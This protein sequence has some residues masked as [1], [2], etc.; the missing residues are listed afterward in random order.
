MKSKII[1]MFVFIILFCVFCICNISYA[2]ETGVVYIESDKE[3]IEKDDEVEVSINLKDAKT[4]AC[5]FS[6]YFD[7]SKFEFISETENVNV[8]ENKILC[9]WYDINGGKTPKEGELAKFKFKAKEDGIA[10]FVIEGEF[11]SETGQLI[12]TDFK[13]KQVQIKEKKGI[14]EEQKEEKGRNFQSENAYLQVLRLDREGIVPTFNKDVYQ[15]YLTIPS[16]INEIEVLAISE[17][18]NAKVEITGNTNLEN[19]INTINI[20]VMSE[21]QSQKKVYSIQVT[22]TDDFEMANTNLEILA[23]ENYLLNPPFDTNKTN[24]NIEISNTVKE[25][26]IFAVPENEN[27]KVNIIG[28]DNLKVGNNLITVTV[29][30]ANGVTKKDYIIKVYKRDLEEEN[31]F[32]EEQKAQI[33]EAKEIYKPEE[34]SSEVDKNEEKKKDNYKLLI[35]CLSLIIFIIIIVVVFI[36]NRKK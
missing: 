24:Y 19:E 27:A 17:N 14:S 26:K 35:V 4:A 12:Q 5:N 32:L 3:I 20:T 22:K 8:V 6:L 15:Y 34:T 9:V 13:E 1:N 11:Y 23:I 16:I 2:T 21:N 36:K 18:P 28:N 7:N 25:L 31:V 33:E 10:T 30:S 29:T